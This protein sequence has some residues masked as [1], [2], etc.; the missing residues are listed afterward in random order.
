MYSPIWS[1]GG[2]T[3]I[4]H[5]RRATAMTEAMRI[6]KASGLRLFWYTM[7]ARAYPRIIGSARER[8]WMFFETVLPL[9]GVVGYV[10]VY[11]T[12]NAPEEYIG[13]V[14]LGG[15]MTAFWLNVLWSMASQLYWDK[16]QG[17]LE[18]YVLCPGPMM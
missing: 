11:K 16:D 15:A 4:H 10:F 13:F 8:S 3:W 5:T 12:L 14:V 2:W 7:W 6:P 1:G 9:M 17:N 18:L